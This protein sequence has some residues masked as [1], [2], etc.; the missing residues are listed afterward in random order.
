MKATPDEIAKL[1]EYLLG[2]CNSVH[3]G[4]EACGTPC[5]SD[6]DELEIAIRVEQ[7]HEMFCCDG[8][9]W[10]FEDSEMTGDNLPDQMCPDCDE[11]GEGDDSD[12]G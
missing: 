12:E 4:I 6:E 11:K 7:D 9:G 1:A 8:C 5:Q 2:T 3:A 10:W